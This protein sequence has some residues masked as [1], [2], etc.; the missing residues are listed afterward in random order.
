MKKLIQS[1]VFY[2]LA[3]YFVSEIVPGFKVNTDLKG[4]I[5]SGLCL[6]ILFV[7]LNPLLKFLFLPINIITLGLFS[8]VSQIITFYIFLNLFPHNFN[9]ISWDFSGM[10]LTGLGLH[11]NSFTVTPFLTIIL[12]TGLIS[13]IVS[14]LFLLV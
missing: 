3:I 4:L 1:L 9:I 8:F 6:A 7:F 11:L 2:T 14:L 10:E 5:V 12:S 13:I